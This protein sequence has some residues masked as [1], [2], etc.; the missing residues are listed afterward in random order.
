MM[1]AKKYWIL[2]GAILISSTVV[3]WATIRAVSDPETLQGVKGIAVVI[4]ILTP[5]AKAVGLSRE[6]LRT[7]VELKLR[8]A[9]VKVITIRKKNLA[10]ALVP[11]L[12]LNL[13]VVETRSNR[14]YAYVFGATL[15]FNQLVVLL[16]DRDIICTATTWDK[17]QGGVRVGTGNGSPA[18]DLTNFAE[19]IVEI[20]VDEF[21]NDYLAANPPKPQKRSEN[22]QRRRR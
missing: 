19:E 16:R 4:E 14:A 10:E 18:T 13:N 12:Y 11:S 3:C 17:Q 8:M 9:G 7:L 1:K 20:V 22:L 15:N 5:D 6:R 2:A 21:L